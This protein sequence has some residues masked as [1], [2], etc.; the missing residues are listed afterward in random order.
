ML[1]NQCLCSLLVLT[2]RSKQRTFW[3]PLLLHVS[4]VFGRQQ[5]GFYHNMRG[6]EYRGGGSILFLEESHLLERE[7]VSPRCSL[8]SGRNVVPSTSRVGGS[9]KTY[10]VAK[11]RRRAS[12]CSFSFLLCAPHFFTKG[13]PHARCEIIF[14]SYQ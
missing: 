10:P 11:H 13:K 2:Q 6:R 7:T 1:V 8:T 9:K 14:F 5:F 12:T 4:A 3:C